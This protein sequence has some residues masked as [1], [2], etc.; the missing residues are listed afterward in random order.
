MASDIVCV[1]NK[2]YFI[3]KLCDSCVLYNLNYVFF[4]VW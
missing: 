1:E 2:W 4:F 3:V